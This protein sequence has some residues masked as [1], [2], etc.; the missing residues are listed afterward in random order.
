M[1]EYQELLTSLRQ[2]HQGW[3]ELLAVRTEAE[4]TAPRLV[5][6]WSIKD[7]VAHLA[8]WQQISIARMRAAAEGGAP[9]HPDWLGG[10]D[11]FFAEE[12]TDDFNQRIYEQKRQ[13]PWSNVY[14]TWSS[15]FRRFIELCETIPAEH[16]FDRSRH[17]WLKGHDLAAVVRGSRDH[18]LEHLAAVS[19]LL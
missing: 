12:H 13:E 3:E 2:A 4:L 18:H 14:E 11:P 6:A 19:K 16:M 5:G 7:V 15:G 9:Q 8:A 17:E 10:S 1:N